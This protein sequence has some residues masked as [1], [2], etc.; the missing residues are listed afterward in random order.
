VEH[1]TAVITMASGTA[2]RNNAQNIFSAAQVW[3]GQWVWIF[4]TAVNRCLRF[5][6]RNQHTVEKVV[7]VRGPLARPLL[8]GAYP[9]PEFRQ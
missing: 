5:P 6:R 7:P 1:G 4:G 8:E 9:E 2:E 3:F